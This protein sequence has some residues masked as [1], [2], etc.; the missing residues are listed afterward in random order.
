MNITQILVSQPW[1]ERLGMTL[2]HF[3]WQGA[4]LAILYAAARRTVV[5]TSSPQTR[6]LLACGALAAMMAAPL[7][8]W[9]L[10]R[11]ADAS[12]EAMYRIRST[13]AAVP[14]TGI[15]TTRSWPD[16]VRA[17]VSTVG[18]EQ[19]LSWVVMVW[20][21]GAAVFWVRLAGGCVVSARMRSMLVRRAPPEWQERFKKLGARIGISRSVR[22]LV[23][24]LVQVPAVVGWLRPV[25]LVPVGALGGLPAEHLEA[26]LLHELAHIRRNDYLINILQS[27]A[28]S[29]LFYHPA[30]WW[31]SGHIRAERE[32]CCDDLAVSIGGDALTYA[33][34]LAQL[35]SYRPAHLS[36]AMAANRGS[37]PNRVARL[38]GR[39]RP[40]MRTGLGPDV[41]A[42]AGLLV[43]A[44][45]GLFGQSANP[46]RFAVASIKRNPSREQLSMA[47]PMGV[48]YRP[49][50]RL[51]AG[52]APVT[53]LIQ[54]A[55]SVQGFQ[56]VGGPSWINT[57][58]YDIEAKPE[59]N[60]GQNRMWLMLRTLLA[61]RF[62]LAMHNETRNLPVYDL[63]AVKGGP[64]LA[65]PRGGPCS[66]VLTALPERGQPR[67]APPCGPG[68]IKAGTGLTM[69]GI[70]VSMPA[71][72]K[73]LST[74]MGREVIDKTGFTGRFALHLEFASDDALAG[75]P[76][77][78]GLDASG[79]PADPA[80]RP[81]IRTA[82]QE[83]LGMRLQAS[84]GPVDVLVIDHVERP[85]EN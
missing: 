63:E 14:A 80:A 36:T 56:L 66:E 34:A 49:G 28:E 54:R 37:L 21:A 67:P 58:G 68:V 4:F 44:A 79:Q 11:P 55:Y 53:M 65:P 6:Y 48:G 9:Q 39:S 29:L 32:L 81:S 15:A 78:V 18:S 25:V 1:V 64:K 71:F 30:V 76:N 20:L 3:L 51:V 31:V 69:E 22:L 27:L 83:Q 60:T 2:L 84:T 35:E 40:V 73:M 61:D 72:A 59:S 57:D 50:G 19:F 82:L 41:I 85:A 45:Y 5:R 17:T 42:V 43:V 74:L 70:S 77:P 38:L 26:L 12:T 8:T 75:L 10:M 24:A 7:V 23:S 16:S 33:R 62:K 46:P 47:V 52:N 13:P